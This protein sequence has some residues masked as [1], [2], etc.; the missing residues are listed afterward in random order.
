MS[1]AIRDWPI[2]A[3]TLELDG[4]TIKDVSRAFAAHMGQTPEQLIDTS[5]DTILTAASRLYFLSALDPKLRQNLDCEQHTLYLKTPLGGLPFLTSAHPQHT[6]QALLV[7]MPAD[8][9]LVLQQ[10]LIQ[11]RDYTESLNRDLNRQQHQLV[12]QRNRQKEL[13]EKLENTNHEL[14]QT[15]K[16]AA[17]GQLAAGIAHE[18][19]NPVGYIQSNLNSLDHYLTTLLAI[20]ADARGDDIKQRLAAEN[21]DFIKDDLVDLLNE[22]QQGVQHITS[23]TQALT[24]FTRAPGKE[25]TCELHDQINTTLR[26]INNELKNKAHIQRQFI[27]TPVRVKFDPAQ[28]NQVMM[29]LLINAAQ[30]IERFG[31]IHIVSE[32]DG[33]YAKVTITDSGVGMDEHTLNHAIEP[34]FTT[35]PEGEGTGLGLSL[36]YNMIRRHFGKLQIDSDV[37]QGT[38]VTLW[39]PLAQERDNDSDSE[40]GTTYR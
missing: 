31:E 28:L 33:N 40:S 1:Q 25:Q 3:L 8:Q 12:E 32:T 18:I 35:K 2:R 38:T 39:L 19:N 36:V 17:L 16:L 34:F 5:I 21:F 29:N 23:I 22:S 10:Q 14:L 11:E 7:F 24:Q 6:N 9:H 26:V 13:L 15:E 27:Q 37:G 4:R 30:A 20:L